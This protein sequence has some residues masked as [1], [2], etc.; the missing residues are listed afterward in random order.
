M[1]RYVLSLLCVLV[2]GVAQYGALTHAVWHVHAPQAEAAHHQHAGHERHPPASRQQSDLCA[3]HAI[4]AQVLGGAT[5]TAAAVA[6]GD[7]V[8]VFAAWPYQPRPSVAAVPAVS[9]G[10]PILL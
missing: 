10:P 7:A 3:F 5:A 9:R 6:A 1:K 2:L 4:F 8:P